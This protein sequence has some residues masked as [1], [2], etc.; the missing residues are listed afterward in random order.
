MFDLMTF[1]VKKLD[2][3]VCEFG[4]HVAFLGII[5]G[6]NAENQSRVHRGESPAY[7]ENAFLEEIKEYRESIKG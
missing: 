7:D 4:A 6:M 1:D 2:R 5:S 3:I